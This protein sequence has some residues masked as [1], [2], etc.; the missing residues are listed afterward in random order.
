MQPLPLRFKLNLKGRGCTDTGY[1]AA[2]DLIWSGEIGKLKTLIVHTTSRL[3]NGASHS[4]DVANRLNDDSP[5]IWVQ[6][7]ASSFLLPT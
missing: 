6:L 4:L 5:A 7:S 2:H 1:D 3:F